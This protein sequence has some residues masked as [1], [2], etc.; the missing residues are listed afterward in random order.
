MPP[1]APFGQ[2]ALDRKIAVDPVTLLL[3]ASF[4]NRQHALV[5]PTIDIQRFLQTDLLVPRLNQIH[6]YLWL[7]GRPVPPQP[8]N[9]LVATSR[10]ITVDERIDMHMVWEKSRRIHLKPLPQYL[11]DH[12]FWDSHLICRGPCCIPGPDSDQP[13]PTT[14]ECTKELSQS[15][16]RYKSDFQIA[17]THHLLPENLDWETWLRLV[18][19]LLESNAINPKNINPRYLYGELRLSRLNKI[20][21]IRHLQVF[22]GYQFTRHTYGEIFREYLTPLTAATIYVAL[23]LTAMQVGLA[24]TRLNNSP[25]FQNASYGFTAFA[26]LGPLV[27]IL[28]VVLIWAVQFI[29][30]LIETCQFNR[31]RSVDIER[32]GL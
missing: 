25:A 9:Y 29:T 32:S 10:E 7:A 20:Y 14:K 23:V 24:T 12:H 17:R 26:I 1:Q 21:A 30:N 31:H 13:P 4:R 28:L 16:I 8:L 11:L 3:P 6:P 19:H 27:G 18:Q 15:L 5:N 22:R 2:E